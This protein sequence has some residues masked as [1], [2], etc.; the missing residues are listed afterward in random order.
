MAQLAVAITGA[1]I[2]S[3][4]PIGPAAGWVIGSAI[5]GAL[6]GPKTKDSGVPKLEDL[7]VES[8]TYGTPIPRIYGRGRARGIVLWQSER[9]AT[10]HT[11]SAG[12]KGGGGAKITSYT[13]SMDILVMFAE[14]VDAV[15][16]IWL[17]GKLYYSQ[18]PDASIEDLTTTDAPWDDLR[19]HLGGESQL[20]DPLYETAVGEGQAPAYRGVTTVMFENLQLEDFGNTPPNITAELLD[21]PLTYLGPTIEDGKNTTGN[22]K[23]ATESALWV[24]STEGYIDYIVDHDVTNPT[25]PT[26][27]TLKYERWSYD[28]EFIDTW[29]TE[30]D[31][32]GI[33]EVVCEGSAATSFTIQGVARQVN[34]VLTCRIRESF[35]GCTGFY[36]SWLSGQVTDGVPLTNTSG[37][38]LALVNGSSLITNATDPSTCDVA[39][40]HDEY[41]YLIPGPNSSGQAS[42]TS[43]IYRFPAPNGKPRNQAD[44]EV[45]LTPYTHSDIYVSEDGVFVVGRISN[46]FNHLIHLNFDLEVQDTWEITN[47][48]DVTAYP[49][50]PHWRDGQAII[51]KKSGTGYQVV[52]LDS[53]SPNTFTVIETGDVTGEVGDASNGFMVPVNDIALHSN[54]YIT[55]G[56]PDNQALTLASIIT[57]ECA[58]VGLTA[59]DIDVAELTD[60]VS[61]YVKTGPATI[62]EF[63]RPLQ[64]A[65][66]F[67]I[68]SSGWKLKFVK[69]KRPSIAAT[70]AYTDLAVHPYGQP[71]PEPLD[72]TRTPER[73]LPKRI[74]VNY[75]SE[76]RDYQTNSQYAAREITEGDSEELLEL[77]IL[78]TDDE[79]AQAAAIYLADQ[80]NGRDA[81][82]PQLGIKYLYLDPT[83]VV[84]VN[85]P[86]A[87]H[88]MR[89][90]NIELFLPGQLNMRGLSIRP[91]SLI[92]QSVSYDPDNP[93]YEETFSADQI[94]DVYTSTSTGAPSPVE[95]TSI[96]PIGPTEYH[97]LD[98]PILRVA[99]NNAGLY[100]A[101]KG[102][103]SGWSGAAMFKSTDGNA[104]AEIDSVNQASTFGRVTNAL[105]SA[106]S[107]VIDRSSTLNVRVN[108]ML[109]SITD[110]QFYNRENLAAVGDHGRWEIIAYRDATLESDGT[111]TI[112]HLLRGLRG[113]EH[114]I[115]NHTSTDFFI[116]LT[117]AGIDRFLLEN[118]ELNIERFYKGVSVGRS[119]AT[120]DAEPFTSALISL[121]PL[122]PANVR[123]YRNAAGDIR[124]VWRRRSRA[125]IGWHLTSLTPVAED[126]QSYEI[127][128]LNGASVVRTITASTPTAT[129]TAAQ[130][131]TDFGTT[132]SSV[133]IKLYQISA[134]VDRGTVTEATI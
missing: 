119:L 62:S 129:Y 31:N 89:I 103:N 71:T 88:F 41:I 75:I 66:Q 2:G 134:V 92:D 130:Q 131:T 33:G 12:G 34:D 53:G 27:V 80:W 133:D 28:G 24:N 72:T 8:A 107:T 57:N 105:A 78:L 64:P 46:D 10:K 7:T 51:G 44:K 54:Q 23:N 118:D 56:L 68:F 39:W 108:K 94:D 125:E 38:K 55:H 29:S 22:P 127:D 115:G 63:S 58:D 19:I 79:A 121:K 76:D 124:I 114:N 97:L 18:H 61:G 21:G 11:E 91:P 4:T 104:Y 85:T 16:K 48:D 132:Q 98:I 65:Y 77:P 120:A 25:P 42:G 110:A 117:E 95:Q 17:N 9:R 60:G 50:G 101:A 96:K 35:G 15:R 126:S 47:F 99:D 122:A 20:P 6:F 13:Y 81:Y 86:A 43:L 30:Y 100:W 83:D 49:S 70:I 59:D 82:A 37:V 3:I 1:A 45:D 87:S 93:T 116:A 26:A 111:Y 123:A 73:E 67:D 84:Q 112:D 52:Q 14:S 113:T 74:N 90:T 36:A 109:S 69:R 128:I 106:S 102:F 5:G 40:Y 32:P